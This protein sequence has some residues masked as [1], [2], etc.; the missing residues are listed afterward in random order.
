MIV[1]VTNPLQIISE[2]YRNTCRIQYF[3][4]SLED[5][6]PKPVLNFEDDKSLSIMNQ[7]IS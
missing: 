3:I 7:T 6:L 1:K 2:R 4:N 5:I